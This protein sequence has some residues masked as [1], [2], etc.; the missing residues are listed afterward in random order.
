MPS[1]GV[2]ACLL[3]WGA[4]ECMTSIATWIYPC[5]SLCTTTGLLPEPGLWKDCQNLSAFI[6]ILF[7]F[8][9]KDAQIVNNERSD[10]SGPSQTE[11]GCCEMQAFKES[12]ESAGQTTMSIMPQELHLC[13]LWTPSQLQS[14]QCYRFLSLPWECVRSPKSGH[15]PDWALGF[16]RQASDTSTVR[17]PTP[18][19]TQTHSYE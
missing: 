8:L 17:T 2:V 5:W 11:E 15:P 7:L 1:W 16:A 10:T 13:R 19:N 18:T 14:F 12:I 3:I 9:S 4:T 6:F